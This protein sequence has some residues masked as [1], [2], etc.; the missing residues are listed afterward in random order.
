MPAATPQT[1]IEA[2]T[3]RRFLVSGW[4]WRSAAYLVTTVPLVLAAGVPLGLL[5]AP[6]A[7]LLR[8]LTAW[9]EPSLAGF[10]LLL[11]GGAV[12]LAVLGPAVALPL[13]AVER[14][15]L[16]IVDSR[17]VGSGHRR[18]PG[19]GP[20]P[21]LRTRYTEAATWR[22]LA[23]A[24]LLCTVVPV[25]YLAALILL[26]LVGVLAASP[27]LV[28]GDGPV[29]LGVGEVTTAGDAVP[30]MIAGIALLPAVPYLL[31]LLAGAQGALARVLLS[32]GAGSQLRA[33][34]VEVSRSRARLV[35]AF[36]AER[37]RIERDL[38]DGAQ[39]RLVG[40]TLQLGLARLDLPGDTPAGRAVASAHDQAKQLMAE[41]RELIHGIRPQVLTD[42]GLPAA[43]RELA[44]QAPI[45]VTVHADLPV[46]PP[47]HVETAA[48]FVAAEALA[49]VAKHSGA[50]T[51]G[52]TA[53]RH[54]DTLTVEVRDDGRGGA[55]PARGS[56]LT[57]LADRVSVVD[58]RMFVSSPAGGPTLVRV[59]LSCS[60]ADQPS[61]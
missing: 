32:A 57:G 13:A 44:D 42:L 7:V 19:V 11:V 51:A 55:D 16:R 46:R 37:H 45:P 34:L 3:R 40:L 31:A 33:E 17:P 6:W 23:Y 49:N 52:V 36:E 14:R 1:A 61:A 41:L 30:Y 25:A 20:G 22:E 38:H 10:A 59:E 54:G 4:P 39:Q 47:P 27:L 43:L 8:S 24:A 50:T 35:D 58:G 29:S 48:Y 12:L 21:W 53:T 5:A 56:G 9:E 2:V 28:T 26:M 15:R 18:P 60:R